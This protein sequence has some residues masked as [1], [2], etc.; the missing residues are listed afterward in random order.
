VLSN[1]LRDVLYVL[2]YRTQCEWQY[3]RLEESS[4]LI[5]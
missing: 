3:Y 1:Y 4:E 5:I 2:I